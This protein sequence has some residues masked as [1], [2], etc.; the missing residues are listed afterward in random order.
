MQVSCDHLGGSEGGSQMI[1]VDHKGGRGGLEG[2]KIWS[3]L[4][5]TV[6]IWGEGGGWPNDHTWSQR[7]EGGSEK[8]QNMILRYLNGPLTARWLCWER[9]GLSGKQMNGISV[10]A[11]SQLRSFWGGMKR[12]GD[13][14]EEKTEEYDPG[15]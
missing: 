14:G 9:K 11:Y 6:I 13:E 7:G 2:A 4:V 10:P 5:L 3:H 12:D 15:D 1:T 8:G